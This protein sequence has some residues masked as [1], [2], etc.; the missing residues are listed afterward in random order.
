NRGNKMICNGQMCSPAQG[1]FPP[2]GYS[3]Y[4]LEPLC[5]PMALPVTSVALLFF[6]EDTINDKRRQS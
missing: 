4:E 5:T 2:S 6:Y 3:F 1:I